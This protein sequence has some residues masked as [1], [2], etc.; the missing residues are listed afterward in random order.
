MAKYVG[1]MI[2]RIDAGTHDGSAG[3]LTDGSVAQ[4]SLRRPRLQE[5]VGIFRGWAAVPDVLQDCIADVL[6]E[7]QALSAVRFTSQSDGR[8]APIDVVERDMPDVA[9]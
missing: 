5:H 2:R 9:T 8:V 4:R 1:P 6:R 7:R 3:D